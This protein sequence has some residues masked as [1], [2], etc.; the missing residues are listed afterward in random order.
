MSTIAYLM[1]RLLP[2]AALYELFYELSYV[3]IDI[4]Y[5]FV[6]YPVYDTLVTP[7]FTYLMENK[8]LIVLGGAM[9]WLHKW[10]T[11]KYI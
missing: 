1:Y 5:E 6:F 9:I 4:W 3:F 2:L 8:L 10:L 11:R 7:A